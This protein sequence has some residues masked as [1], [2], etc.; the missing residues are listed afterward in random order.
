MKPWLFHTRKLVTM[1]ATKSRLLMGRDGWSAVLGCATTMRARPQAASVA[2]PLNVVHGAALLASPVLP[3]LHAQGSRSE[4]PAT[5]ALVRALFERTGS[6]FEPLRATSNRLVPEHALHPELSASLCY[7]LTLGDGPWKAKFV[8]DLLREWALAAGCETARVE[9]SF[10]TAEAAVEESRKDGLDPCLGLAAVVAHAWRRA[11]DKEELWV[12]TDKL[13]TLEPGWG[14]DSAKLPE[15]MRTSQ[16]AREF[17]CALGF[18]EHH[19][20]LLNQ[21]IMEASLSHPTVS[22]LAFE[23]AVGAVARYRTQGSSTHVALVKAD[24]TA[25]RQKAASLVRRHAPLSGTAAKAATTSDDEDDDG[26]SLAYPRHD[27]A[28]EGAVRPP[29]TVAAKLAQRRVAEG[30]ANAWV[31]GGRRAEQPWLLAALSS[32]AV[33]DAVVDKSL[34][35]NED[36]GG[37]PRALLV[38]A[39]PHGPAGSVARASL[40]ERALSPPSHH[41]RS[42]PDRVAAAL[43]FAQRIVSLERSF[44]PQLEPWWRAAVARAIFATRVSEQARALLVD[45]LAFPDLAVA[46]HIAAEF[47]ALDWLQTLAEAGVDLDL[48]AL[49][50]GRP[51]AHAARTG[52]ISALTYLLNVAKVAPDNPVKDAAATPLAAAAKAGDTKAVSLLLAYGADPN[53]TPASDSDGHAPLHV[54]KNVEVAN[55]LVEAGACPRQRSNSGHTPFEILP[56]HVTRYV[57]LNGHRARGLPPAT[58]DDRPFTRRAEPTKT[59][60][61][62]CS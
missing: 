41:K 60:P 13:G 20:E 30:L 37:I 8:S 55:L 44:Q 25:A 58:S 47:D 57:K 45:E 6:D 11:V 49:D 23:T 27:A 12:F 18:E 39:V 34:L 51:L 38:A 56:A 1:R 28:A 3:N 10:A 54:A 17:W 59:S 5:S 33:V 53:R 7:A 29:W 32:P 22:P 48:P 43:C 4:Y 62:S 21:A 50:G 46:P 15:S 40:V 2:S 31:D 35:N 42:S 19:D 36:V 26:H 9:A 24:E 16:G 52:A 61:L 14:L